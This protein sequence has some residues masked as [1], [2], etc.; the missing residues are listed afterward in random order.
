MKENETLGIVTE[1]GVFGELDI[2]DPTVTEVANKKKK[3]VDN[4]DEMIAES[5]NANKNITV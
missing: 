2:N 1:V 3:S 5:I 4:I